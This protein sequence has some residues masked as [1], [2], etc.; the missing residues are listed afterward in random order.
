MTKQLSLYC[1][2]EWFRWRMLVVMRDFEG[3]QVHMEENVHL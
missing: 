1:D 3:F 2:I